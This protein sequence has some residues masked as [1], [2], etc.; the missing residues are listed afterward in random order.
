ML[1][2]LDSRNSISFSEMV[3]SIENTERG[4]F[5]GCFR[6]Q[7]GHLLGLFKFHYITALESIYINDSTN[8][9]SY[10][11][12]SDAMKNLY[13]EKGFDENYISE[14]W[15]A[16]YML[17]TLLEYFKTEYPWVSWINFSESRYRSN[18][19]TLERLIDAT[20]KISQLILDIRWWSEWCSW[21]IKI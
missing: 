5:Y 3:F 18:T 1:D 15:S 16:K 2:I 14:P 21:T 8:S 10:D 4:W 19:I 13:K 6:D 11:Y 7:A 17:K 9:S 12:F 20:Q